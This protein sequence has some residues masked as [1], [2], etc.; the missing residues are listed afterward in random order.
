VAGRGTPAASML[1]LLGSPRP[2]SRDLGGLGRGLGV[3]ARQPA[4]LTRNALIL[5]PRPQ[6][7][8]LCAKDAP[9]SPGGPRPRPPRDAG[10]DLRPANRIGPSRGPSPRG[11]HGDNG[12]TRDFAGQR[13]SG[14]SAGTLTPSPMPVGIWQPGKAEINQASRSFL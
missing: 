1:A 9:R 5:R 2:R 12:F 8:P 3:G 14:V 13:G 4:G 11:G 7:R 10:R 6:S